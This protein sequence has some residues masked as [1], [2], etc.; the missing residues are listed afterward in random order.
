[1]NSRHRKTL[2]AI[3]ATP[4][5]ASIRFADIEALVIAL[6]G[7][8]REGNGSRVSLRL[9]DGIKNAHR[10]HPGKDAKKY[11]IEEIRHWLAALGE[12]P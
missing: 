6:G 10:P 2:E 11:Q 5:S 12:T 1:M 7:E 3:F 9:R 8:V 4:T